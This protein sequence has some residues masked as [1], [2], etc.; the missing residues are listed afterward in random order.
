M[1]GAYFWA[2]LAP[3]LLALAAPIAAP[4][5]LA[6]DRQATPHQAEVQAAQLLGAQLYA[7]DQVAWHGTDAFLADVEREG[8][9]TSWLRGF[10]VLPDPTGSLWMVFYGDREGRAGRSGALSG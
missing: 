10:L 1:T 6:Q 8:F 3:C 5:L 9:D 2:R 7:Y 4:P